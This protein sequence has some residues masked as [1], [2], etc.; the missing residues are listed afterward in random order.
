MYIQIINLNICI[1]PPPF[2]K[3]KRNPTNKHQANKTFLPIF[4]LPTNI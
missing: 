3:K 2:K 1:T 4:G